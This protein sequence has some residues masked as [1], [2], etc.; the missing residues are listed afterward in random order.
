MCALC[1]HFDE[2]MYRFT[3]FY[4]S[5]DAKAFFDC[6]KIKFLAELFR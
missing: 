6:K 3:Y 4:S 5:F 1:I 2:N